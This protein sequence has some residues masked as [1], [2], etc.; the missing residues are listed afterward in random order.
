MLRGGSSGKNPKHV[1]NLQ[2]SPSRKQGV[3]V[4]LHEDN[5]LRKILHCTGLSS[6]NGLALK[7]GGHMDAAKYFLKSLAGVTRPAPA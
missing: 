4:K 7:S 3:C 6:A 5:D 2:H 1:L